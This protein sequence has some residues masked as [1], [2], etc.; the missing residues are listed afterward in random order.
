MVT[1]LVW[2][3][4]C[5]NA[6]LLHLLVAL[7]F[8]I[9]PRFFISQSMFTCRLRYVEIWRFWPNKHNFNILSIF[10]YLDDIKLN[11]QVPASNSYC[12]S[13]WS[14]FNPVPTF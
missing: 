7:I 10:F 4:F 14:L 1:C 6:K 13:M 9:G 11:A 12:R 3:G 2:R 5:S 8:Y